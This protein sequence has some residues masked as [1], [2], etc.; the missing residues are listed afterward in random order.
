MKALEEGVYVGKE[1]NSDNPALVEVIS[2]MRVK[3][4]YRVEQSKIGRRKAY[5]AFVRRQYKL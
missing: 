3:A 4:A 1:G 2:S 5:N